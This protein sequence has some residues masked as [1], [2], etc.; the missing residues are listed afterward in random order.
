[1]EYP[2]NSK[3]INTQMNKA[4]FVPDSEVTVLL[5]NN[6][7]DKLEVLPKCK[8]NRQNWAT[9]ASVSVET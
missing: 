5:N 1:L 2:Q 3:I 4:I 6:Q 7:N 9:L 8:K